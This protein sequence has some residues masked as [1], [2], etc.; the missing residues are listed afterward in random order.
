MTFYRK[1]KFVVGGYPQSYS[2]TGGQGVYPGVRSEEGATIIAVESEA[3]ALRCYQAGPALPTQV[4]RMTSGEVSN[5]V[6]VSI[7][8]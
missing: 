5:A 1:K 4:V 2:L 6:L 8:K 7:Y 3:G